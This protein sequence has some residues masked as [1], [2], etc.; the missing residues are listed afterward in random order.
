MNGAVPIFWAYGTIVKVCMNGDDRKVK[1][2][3]LYREL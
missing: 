1:W 3:T 2:Y